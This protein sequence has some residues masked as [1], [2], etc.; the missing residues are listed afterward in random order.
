[1]EFSVAKDVFLK[2]LSRVQSIIEKKTTLPIL[3]NVLIDAKTDTIEILAT[4]LTVGIK[5]QYDA[6]VKEKGS[7]TVG[8]KKLFEIVRELPEQEVTFKT[9]ENNWVE[10]TCGKAMFKIVGLPADDF[11]ILPAYDTEEFFPLPSKT[12]SVMIEKVQHAISMDETRHY[13]N[14]MYFTTAEEDNKKLLRMVSTDGH[15]LAMVDREMDKESLFD[16]KAGCI[17]P[18]KG[19]QE[20]RKAF[21]D[22]EDDAMICMKDRSLVVKTK[23]LLFIIRLIDGDFPDY[24]QVIPK[25]NE[26]ILVCPRDSLLG[27]LRRISLI[28][29]EMTRGIKFTL[30]PKVLEVSSSNPELGEAKEEI[31]VT[32]ESDEMKIGFN[33]R[34]FLDVLSVINDEDV[35]IELAD[36]MSPGIIKSPSDSGYLS[37]IMPMRL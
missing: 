22:S 13:L 4:D 5:G 21:G 30:K 36:E 6:Q 2:G 28:S 1:M 17:I 18:R 27:A 26:R 7:V 32:Y 24:T 33:A 16:L 8:A 9:L 11:P 15:R 23:T 35:V 29:S 10:L 12:L 14:G 19:I 20:L 37:V 25:G 31:V 3:T 34:Y